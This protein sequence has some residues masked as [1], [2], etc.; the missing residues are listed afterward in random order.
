LSA[1]TAGALDFILGGDTQNAGQIDGTSPGVYTGYFTAVDTSG[2][3]LT[4]SSDF[5]GTIT[6]ISVKEFVITGVEFLTPASTSPQTWRMAPVLSD[7]N[8]GGAPFEIA[9]SPDNGATWETVLRIFASPDGNSFDMRSSTNGDYFLICQGD[10]ATLGVG[11]QL[12]AQIELENAS[13][14]VDINLIGTVLSFVGDG[15]TGYDMDNTLNTTGYSVNG[16][17]G[18]SGTGTVISSITVENGIITAITVV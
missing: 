1:G 17:A 10:Y 9:S 11:A 14:L 12:Q 6:A 8:S 18:A 13:A 15:V 5:D 16:N 4:P 3:I 7:P 2:L